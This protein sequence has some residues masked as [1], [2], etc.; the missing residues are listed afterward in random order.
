MVDENLGRK[1]NF[2]AEM[3][4]LALDYARDPGT[5]ITDP[6]MAVAV[7]FNSAG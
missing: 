1:D 4:M 6:E 3:A 7:H 2:F 5:A